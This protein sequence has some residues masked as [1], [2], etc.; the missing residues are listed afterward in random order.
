[1][2]SKVAYF[3][4]FRN[5]KSVRRYLNINMGYCFHVS[6]GVDHSQSVFI[7]Q[8]SSR[9]NAM[10]TITMQA[11][12]ITG[13]NMPTSRKQI[14]LIPLFKIRTLNFSHNLASQV[15]ISLSS[16]SVQHVATYA[17]NTIFITTYV[18]NTIYII[19]SKYLTVLNNSNSNNRLCKRTLPLATAGKLFF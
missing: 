15:Y 4:V 2:I 16:V 11:T 3:Q 14:Q 7:N 19:L 12:C 17:H 6:F 13:R 18:R 8:N 1:M 9:Y 5:C 10:H